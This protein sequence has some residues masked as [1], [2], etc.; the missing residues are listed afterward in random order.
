[1]CIVITKY[2]KETH[3][4][5]H[6]I[7]IVQI[8]IKT[9]FQCVLYKRRTYHIWGS[10]RT[11][12]VMFKTV[13][14][15]ALLVLWVLLMKFYDNFCICSLKFMKTECDPIFG[16]RKIPFLYITRDRY[17]NTNCKAKSN[18]D[19]LMACKYQKSTPPFFKYIFTIIRYNK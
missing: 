13:R 6:V 15:R 11:H 1:M 16:S 10:S 4:K 8:F 12:Q 2:S 7:I 9:C 18:S 5:I 19:F 17:P 14:I 3:N